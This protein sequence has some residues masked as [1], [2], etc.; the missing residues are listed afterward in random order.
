MNY[1]FE[2]LD[3]EDEE[4]YKTSW[5][6]F[7]TTLGN[8][9]EYDLFDKNNQVIQTVL[10]NMNCFERIELIKLLQMQSQR[11]YDLNINIDVDHHTILQLQ[12]EG[13]DVENGSYTANSISEAVDSG[14]QVTVRY[15]DENPGDKVDFSNVEDKSFYSDYVA[16]SDIQNFLERPVKIYSGSWAEDTYLDVNLQVWDLYFN[17]PSVRRKLDNFAWLNCNLNVKIMINSSPFYYGALLASYRP[18]TAFNTNLDNYNLSNYQQQTCALNMKT[19][20]PNFWIYPQT[21]QGGEMKLPFF[22]PRN[23]IDVN[24][25]SDFQGMGTLSLNSA[26]VLKNA[27]G[28][29]GQGVTITMFAWAS[30]VYLSGPT[31]DLALQSEYGS[32][33]GPA[34]AVAK[35]SSKLESVPLIGAYAKATSMVAST[36]GSVAKIFGFTNTPVVSD[37]QPFKNTAFHAF[38]SPEISNPIEKLSVDPKQELCIDNRVAG[39]NGDDEHLISNL[40]QRNALVFRSSWTAAKVPGDLLVCANVTPNITSVAQLGAPYNIPYIQDTPMAHVAG[41]FKDWRG[42][43][44]FGFKFI[45]SKFHRGRVLIQWDPHGDIV[46]SAPETNVVYSQVVDISEETEVEFRV[47]YIQSTPF[48]DTVITTSSTSEWSYVQVTDLPGSLPAYQEEKYNGRLTVRVL[49]NQ[50]SPVISA[51]VFILVS[52][53]GCEN[54]QFASPQDPPNNVSYLLPQ[55]ES[56]TITYGKKQIY[57]MSDDPIVK[58][59]ERYLVNFGE[60]IVSLRQL[61]RRMNFTRSVVLTGNTTEQFTRWLQIHSPQPLYRGY[62]LNGINTATSS[63]GGAP[64]SYNY[65]NMTI[66]NWLAPMYIGYRGGFNYSY[67]FDSPIY[68]NS[69]L[70]SRRTLPSTTGEYNSSGGVATSANLSAKTAYLIGSKDANA[71]GCAL[72][73]QKTQTGLSVYYPMY[74]KFRFRTTAIQYNTLGTNIDGSNRERCDVRTWFTPSFQTSSVINSSYCDHY[75]GV[76]NDFSFVY[77]TNVQPFYYLPTPAA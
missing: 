76:G 70:A 15:L 30:E 33:S 20:R 3:S 68:L 69:C 57:S 4:Y 71:K 13:G 46:N 72:T 9:T 59:E 43:I 77:F 39:I 52:A 58:E 64:S 17:T 32:I 14:M 67:N 47:P 42:D 21:N 60:R 75:V 29:S 56:D 35:V 11:R 53:R 65:C 34:S 12:S 37:V 66:Y 45:C 26:T 48:L 28:V 24:H 22:Y 27:N 41:L 7:N 55:S 40:V 38:A 10:S 8:K 73:N 62:E 2:D 74:S 49:T 23:W 61:L 19:Q 31:T 50:T 6:L 25:R 51:D 16:T 63:I 5:E 1:E 36:I 54:L 18:L 44:I